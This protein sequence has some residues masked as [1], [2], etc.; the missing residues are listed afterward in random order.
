MEMPQIK[1]RSRKVIPKHGR[2]RRSG[3]RV[4]QGPMAEVVTT[5]QKSKGPDT[6]GEGEASQ[7]KD[8]SEN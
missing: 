5:S 7:E 6:T 4:K 8:R 2:F 1:T 3:E